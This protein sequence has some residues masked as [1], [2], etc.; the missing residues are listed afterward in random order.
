MNDYTNFYQKFHIGYYD[1]AREERIRQF[2]MYCFG[3]H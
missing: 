2:C 3:K 1:N